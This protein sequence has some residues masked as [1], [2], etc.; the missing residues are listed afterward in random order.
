MIIT[1]LQLGG[2]VYVI[3]FLLHEPFRRLTEIIV[4]PDPSWS[5]ARSAPRK[6]V[7][8][9]EKCSARD[10]MLDLLVGVEPPVFTWRYCDC[11]YLC[12]DEFF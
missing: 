5:P 3:G 4:I 12:S 7:S 2:D 10:T 8:S 9:A 1:L 6:I 11:C